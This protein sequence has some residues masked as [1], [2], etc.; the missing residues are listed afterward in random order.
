MLMLV[1]L[2]DTLL[3][4]LLLDLVLLGSGASRSFV[5]QSSSRDFVMAIAELECPSRVSIANDNRI[6]A[7]RTF[8]IVP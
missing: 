2:L 1:S 5:S 3:V 8:E 7:M 6:Y 4:N